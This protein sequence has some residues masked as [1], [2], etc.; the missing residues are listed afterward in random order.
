[1][2]PY[3]RDVLPSSGVQEK[4]G[5]KILFINLYPIMHIPKTKDTYYFGTFDLEVKTAPRRP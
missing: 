2:D 1:M 5:Y 3:P 4:Q